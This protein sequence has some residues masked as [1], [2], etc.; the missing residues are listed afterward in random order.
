MMPHAAE[1]MGSTD[2]FALV[3]LIFGGAWRVLSTTVSDECVSYVVGKTEEAP[4]RGAALSGRERTVLVMASKGHAN[5]HI[6][7]TLSLST[8]SVSTLLRR[9][10]DK[11]AGRVPPDLLGALCRELPEAPLAATFAASAPSRASGRG[12]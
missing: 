3:S 11:L 7:A 8:S 6:A 2:V 12:G 5:K 9:A 4:L 1:Q 10:R